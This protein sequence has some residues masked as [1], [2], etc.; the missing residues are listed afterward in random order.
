MIFRLESLPSLDLD[1]PIIMG[2][3]SDCLRLTILWS[4]F[5]ALLTGCLPNLTNVNQAE[6]ALQSI[7]EVTQP[8]TRTQPT[9][10]PIPNYTPADALEIAEAVAENR[11]KIT[12]SPVPTI[13][14]VE[15]R[16]YPFPL[17]EDGENYREIPGGVWYTSSLSA[18]EVQEFYLDDMIY[19]RWSYEI[20]EEGEGYADI[21][22][23]KYEDRLQ[24]TIWENRERELTAISFADVELLTAGLAELPSGFYEG[25]WPILG[26]QLSPTADGGGIYTIDQPLSLVR[27]FYLTAM[28]DAGWLPAPAGREE[29]S[30]L[31]LSF[32]RN[33][34][35]LSFL[36]QDVEDGTMVSWSGGLSNGQ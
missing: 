9:S 31:R 2:F 5:I 7:P 33:D 28:L 22:F 34:E 15:D 12:P 24:L 26:N 25:R 17:L 27:F 21:Q 32:T 14:P 8:A 36:L 4:T 6:V 13:Q 18:A 3:K 35:T 1:A 23:W 19:Y 30:K 29:P 16:E 20:S 11:A 10:T